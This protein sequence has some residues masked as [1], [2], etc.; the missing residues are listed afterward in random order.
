MKKFQYSEEEAQTEKRRFC[1]SENK[2][3]I[4]A[5]CNFWLENKYLSMRKAQ[6]LVCMLFALVASLPAFAQNTQIE[7]ADAEF[8]N[9]GYFLA[10][11]LY[12]QAYD[13]VKKKDDRSTLGRV[14]FQIGECY[15]M[16]TDHAAAVEW[17]EKAVTARYH[18]ENA[19]VYFNLA[20]SLQELGKFDEA[21]AN[22]NKYKEAGGDKALAQGRIEDCE[23]AA[24]NLEQPPTRYLVE[25]EV[26]LNSP[27]FDFSPTWSEKKEDEIVFSSSRSGSA[28]SSADPKTGDSFMD[29]FTAKADKKGKW[30]TPVP[31]NN[32]VNSESNEGA[33]C[34]DDKKSVMYFTRCIYDNKDRFGCDIYTAK[35]TGQ[36]Y[37][38]PEILTIID[39]NI[40]DTSHVG[41]PFLT[42][43]EQYLFFASN[44][45]GGY[46]GRDIWYI[47]YDKKAKT[48]SAPKNLGP[49]VNTTAD[50]MFPYLHDD[51]SLYF[52]SNGH[53]SLGG[54]DIYKAPKA[55]EMQFGKPQNL[56]YPINS[57]S[58]DFGI[59]FRK[60]KDEGLFTSNRPGGKGKD[61]I[62]SFKM[63]PLEFCLKATV[64]DQDTGV[65]IPDA[66]VVVSGSDGSS[67]ELMSDGN[68]GISL[69]DGQIIAETNYTVDVS[70]TGY[71]G[72]GDQFST[73]GLTESTT[74]AREYFLQEIIL[75]KEYNLPLVLYI[76]DKADLVVDEA[77][78]S[79]DSLNYLF[80]IL[81]K[82]PTLVINLEA[83]TDTRGSD[84]YN[85]D[86]SQRRAQTCVDYLVSRG[87]D[88]ARMFA[89]GKGE[90]EPKISDKEINAMATEDE[91]EAA[92]QKN[93]R[94][95][96]TIRSY[97][98]VPKQ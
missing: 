65:P 94:T 88:K 1:C 44:M 16:M 54:L 38:A 80:D 13:K 11:E 84:K 60:G 43:D 74:F 72:T 24:L 28:G 7:S 52:S 81:T 32:T 87:I 48:W 90:S 92:H 77:T 10:A 31:L 33:S 46:G 82:N 79:K 17:Y 89:V 78:N 66:K 5:F 3:F 6:L 50:E 29:L 83:H 30:S 57:S 98:Y 22:Y 18:N 61:D 93:R 55:G 96:F 69:C 40:D 71:I 68:G 47:Q 34:F 35:K 58:D 41:H 37:Q 27:S 23:R 85:Q 9:G 4:F 86:L 59:L 75:E 73:V 26:Q 67:Y 15:R 56:L 2:M 76:F 36:N 42:E 8:R 21:V 91:K 51:G 39:R 14:L 12:K 70:K 63:P 64:Y 20:N 19:D 95:V 62:Y 53:G 45:H 25:N 97:D 49:N